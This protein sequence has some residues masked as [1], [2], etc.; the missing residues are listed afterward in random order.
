MGNAKI[1]KD[2]HLIIRIE[3]DLK[4]DFT[5]INKQKKTKNSKKVR[6]WIEDYVNKNKEYK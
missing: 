5:L 4:Q 1:K 3:K 2:D 6:E